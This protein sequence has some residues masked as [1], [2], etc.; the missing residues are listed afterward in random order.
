MTPPDD[1]LLPIYHGISW[2]HNE[3]DAW[4]LDNWCE[5]NLGPKGDRW[6]IDG[7]GWRFREETDAV[8]FLLR[9]SYD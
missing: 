1:N 7:A 5:T 3:L 6:N 9:W 4:H 2:I 8:W